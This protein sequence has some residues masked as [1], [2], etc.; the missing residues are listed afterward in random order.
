MIGKQPLWVISMLQTLKTVSNA[1]QMSLKLNQCMIPAA[2]QLHSAEFFYIKDF[3]SNLNT[4]RA[5]LINTSLSQEIIS[6]TEL[7]E[8]LDGKEQ[9]G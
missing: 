1:L 6:W 7:C 2:L 4:C 3:L 9:M 8:R 5:S